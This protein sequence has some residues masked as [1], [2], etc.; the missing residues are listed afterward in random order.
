MPK[1][2]PQHKL[3]LKKKTTS[4]EQFSQL[5]LINTHSLNRGGKPD[6]HRKGIKKALV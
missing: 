1:R 6:A 2:V 5:S 3:S 4:I